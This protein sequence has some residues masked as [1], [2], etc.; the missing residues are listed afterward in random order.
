M[1]PSSPSFLASRWPFPGHRAACALV[2]TA[3]LF[4]LWPL[5][6]F[7][8]TVAPVPPSAP[9]AVVP[10]DEE[11]LHLDKFVISAAEDGGSY[12]ATATM[13]ATRIRTELKDVGSAIS[14]VTAQ[15]LKDTGARN[16][17]DLLV[18]TTN[19]EVGGI[20]GNFAGLGDGASL[21]DLEARLSPLTN[22]RIRGLGAADN[23]RDFFLTDIPWDS[24]NTG[25]VDIQRG[26]NAI[27]FGLGSPAG[28]INASINTA[29]FKNEGSVELRTGSY[30]SH[31]ATLDFNHVLLPQELALRFDALDDRT[32]YE[33]RPAF[34][35]DRRD[36]GALRWDPKFLSRGSAHTSLRLNFEHGQIDANRPHIL[37]PTDQITPWFT[38]LNRLAV[39]PATWQGD[40]NV[41]QLLNKLSTGPILAIFGDPAS[42]AGNLGTAIGAP[43]TALAVVKNPS[44]YAP[45]SFS[46]AEQFKVYRASVLQ[47]PSIF[48]YVHQLIDGPNK[49]EWS[50]HNIANVTLAQTFFNDRLGIEAAYDHQQTKRGATTA[51]GESTLTVDI[52]TRLPDGSP[53]PNFGRAYV[54]GDAFGNAAFAST[55]DARRL[56]G[57]GELRFADFMQKSLLTQLLGRHVFTGFWS[58]E[59][60]DGENF[61]WEAQVAA[62]SFAPHTGDI[63]IYNR[64]IGEVNYLGLSLAGRTSAVGANLPG[65]SAVHRAASGTVRYF[66][67]PTAGWASLPV[68]VIGNFDGARV[69]GNHAQLTRDD[70]ESRGIVWQG[71]LLDGLI[72]PMVG[73]RHDRDRSYALDRAPVNPDG[74]ID[75]ASPDYQLSSTPN[76]VVAGDSTSWSVVV[77]APPVVREKLPGHADISL[78]YNCSENFQPQAG[79][80]DVLGSPLPP[81][82]GRT[83]D[84]GIRLGLFDDRVTLK[85]NW[86]Q[87]KVTNDALPGFEGLYALPNAEAWGYMFARQTLANDG[88]GFGG[89]TG[90]YQPVNGQTAADARADGIAIATAFLDPHN[91]PTDS[92][93]TLY[94]ID[95]S[96]WQGFIQGGIPPGFTITGD[97]RSKGV[98]YEITA[99]PAANWNISFNASR[100]DAQSHNLAGSVSAWIEQR[101]AVFNTPVA[102]TSRPSVIGDVRLFGPYP[103]FTVRDLYRDNI[104]V[105]YLIYKL[106]D[107]ANV[108]ELRP[109]RFNFVSDYT[110]KLGRLKGAHFGGAYRWQDKEVVGYP[111]LPTAS[112]TSTAAF[113]LAH[114]YRGPAETNVDLWLGYERKITK[115]YTWHIQLNVNNAFAKRD[116]IPVTVQPDGTLA[117]GRIPEA[118][119]WTVT[120]SI[121]F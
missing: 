97:T 51:G 63:S 30:G 58:R 47:D 86:Y 8:Q 31:R 111:V 92:F 5:P 27:L 118:T 29:A 22:T 21:D 45:K 24:F 6:A 2:I 90:G 41:N 17:Q 95:R 73:L 82:V 72:V 78:F 34:N 61:D 110:F 103:G 77:H 35:H 12:E 28:I 112:A 46:P 53:N 26:P 49:G 25:R 40:P 79:R 96:G 109:W 83:N 115:K 98:E 64:L 108:N 69:N 38:A 114:P 50:S 10:L 85:M 107:G 120:N 36:F 57:F 84:Y 71:F 88:N 37:P 3:A 62:P 56:T 11:I 9:A 13:A 23:T 33:Q 89:Y 76:N 54:T 113:D 1:P 102:G 91:Q 99:Q 7:S 74:T 117:A 121:S 18:Y 70:V 32:E 15:F 43:G 93:Y 52:N 59:Q 14:V 94:G 75:F 105:P 67:V 48:D 65:L 101:W 60:A 119:T 66:D 100:T 81:P 68:T 19:T 16:S 104:W 80:I 116:L 106:K 44:D 55:R 4:A 87:T 39:D 42:G 20:G